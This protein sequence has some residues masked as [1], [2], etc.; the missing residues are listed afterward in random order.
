MNIGII[1]YEILESFLPLNILNLNEDYKLFISNRTDS[2]LD[3]FKNND[4]VV[5]C[6]S[7][8]E[9]AL[10]CDKIIIAVKSP[11]LIDVI[12]EINPYLKEDAFIIHTCAGIEFDE[13]SKVI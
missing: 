3:K 6:S 7:N 11:Q 9:V 1:G 10:N 5:I 4:D 12:A 2:K 13:I 8:N